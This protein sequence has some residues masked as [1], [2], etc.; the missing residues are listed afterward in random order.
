MAAQF[1]AWKGSGNTSEWN[2]PTPGSIRQW[3]PRE[4]IHP[5][6]KLFLFCF[7]LFPSFLFPH[8][9]FVCTFWLETEGFNFGKR[10]RTTIKIYS[11]VDLPI[12]PVFVLS[13]HQPCS[14][15]T[16]SN[17]VVYFDSPSRKGKF[18]FPYNNKKTENQI[19]RFVWSNKR[20]DTF[21]QIFT[22]AKQ[23]KRVCQ[24]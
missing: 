22:Q 12:S 24:H 19:Q 13:F 16:D 6:K 8:I 2:A 20:T 5:I 15:C 17:H 18:P 9:F 4:I 1:N 7:V 21:R 11:I 3:R 14:N 10:K 23:R